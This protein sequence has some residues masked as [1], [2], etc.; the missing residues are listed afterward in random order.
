MLTGERNTAALGGLV[1]RTSA[2]GWC[3]GGGAT[4]VIFTGAEVAAFAAGVSGDRR[5]RV[6]ARRHVAPEQVERIC[7][8]HVGKQ[9][10]RR[11]AHGADAGRVGEILH[12]PHHIRVEHPGMDADAGRGS[13]A[14]PV[15]RIPEADGQRRCWAA[16]GEG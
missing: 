14:L 3:G 15:G 13:E 12:R 6:S 9:H 7:G 4:T 16:A 10:A 8:S 2:A 5:E 1:I 11:V